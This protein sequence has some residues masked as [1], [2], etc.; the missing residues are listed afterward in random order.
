MGCR[1]LH[2]T[3][4]TTRIQLKKQLLR[5]E[6]WL[7]L[8]YSIDLRNDILNKALNLLNHYKLAV[9][10]QLQLDLLGKRNNLNNDNPYS[11]VGN[12][13]VNDW[14]E[15][16]ESSLW[17][18]GKQ[19]T[20]LMVCLYYQAKPPEGPS[21]SCKGKPPIEG[22]GTP[23][24]DGNDSDPPILPFL[25]LDPLPLHGVCP[26]LEPVPFPVFI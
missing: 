22:P 1:K 4:N 7:D 5:I 9:Q 25:S 8:V 26:L 21:S 13:G 11:F 6:A 15:L 2:I 19:M 14:D 18:W 23:G 16:G 17:N 24:G 20:M 3:D 12:N 10:Y